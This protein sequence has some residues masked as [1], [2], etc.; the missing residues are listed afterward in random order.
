FDGVLVRWGHQPYI[1]IQ[2]FYS[3]LRESTNDVSGDNDFFGIYISTEGIPHTVLDVYYMGQLDEVS[4]E[5]Q[6]SGTTVT[7]TLE[8]A[9]HTTGARLEFN[10][11]GF[12]AEAEAVFQFGNRTDPTNYEQTLDHFATAYFADISYQIP[13][14]T[15][16]TFGAFFVWA[17]GDANPADRKSVDFQPL[18]PTR[19][20][21]LGTMDLFTW[22]N[23]MDIGGTFEL[24]PPMGF[25]FYSGFHYFLLAQP[26][27]RLFGTASNFTPTQSV[28]RNVGMEFDIA[29]TWSPNPNLQLQTGYS[30][31][32]PSTVPEQLGLGN[33]LAHW[34][35]V[36]AR[37]TY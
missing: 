26:Q 34:T 13:V 1:D 17:S 33:D 24:T 23:I 9:I 31:F 11:K 10:Y 37:V 2:A 16:P 19:H 12:R 18:F 35:W 32:L 3:K 15:R 20:S 4:R 28:G 29:L 14:N 22:S 36:Q 8:R 25:G 6:D 21:F 27:G 5:V 7:R 30:V